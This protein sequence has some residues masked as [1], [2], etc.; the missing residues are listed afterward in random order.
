MLDYF[1]AADAALRLHVAMISF[2]AVI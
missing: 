1:A 2:H